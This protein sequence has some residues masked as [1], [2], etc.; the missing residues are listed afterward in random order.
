MP[1]KPA[2]KPEDAYHHGNLRAALL[3]AAHAALAEGSYESLSMRELARAAGVSANAPYRHFESKQAL[4]AA[5]AAQGFDELSARFD[6]VTGV[7][8]VDR[9]N[10]MSDVYTGFAVEHPALYRVMFGSAKRALMGDPELHRAARA[11]FGR[12][13]AA[14]IA[15]RGS[16]DPESA[17][18]L[19]EAVGM[20]SIVH[21][22]AML[23]IDGVTGF[24][25]AA[26]VP[27]AST[28]S[29][30][31]TDGWRKPSSGPRTPTP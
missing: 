20:W 6:R 23:A 1:R 21:G 26:A 15:A 29:R 14:V 13:V 8:A 31:I 3:A 25:P 2:R 27:P 24:L 7:D 19:R 5:V 22:H 9:L 17:D 12:L 10:R 18:T 30:A 11:S 4:L 16:G 28:V